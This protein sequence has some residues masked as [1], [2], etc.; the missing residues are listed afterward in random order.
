MNGSGLLTTTEQLYSPLS[1]TNRGLNIKD[2]TKLLPLSRREGG[3]S[4]T[5]VFSEVNASTDSPP[6]VQCMFTAIEMFIVLIMKAVQVMVSR[7]PA[8]SG[9]LLSAMTETTGGGTVEKEKG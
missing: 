5:L 8:Y 9:P 2:P 6:S 4:V 1:L 7:F 3:I